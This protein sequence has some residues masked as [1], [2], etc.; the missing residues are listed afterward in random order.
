[1]RERVLVAIVVAVAGLLLA[2]PTAQAQCVRYVSTSYGHF[3]QFG[4]VADGVTNTIDGVPVDMT[5]GPAQI[6]GAG[7]PVD[8]GWSTHGVEGFRAYITEG[9]VPTEHAFTQIT[10]WV[11]TVDMKKTGIKGDRRAIPPLQVY[12]LYFDYRGE[13]VLSDGAGAFKNATGHVVTRGPFFLDLMNMPD[14]TP[15][16]AAVFGAGSGEYEFET[17]GM[18]CGADLKA[19]GLR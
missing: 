4:W 2:G 8:R 18:I 7:A 5:A 17:T 13:G 16:P 19:L 10:R 6:E 3:G 11:G 9:G 15:V 14:G 1:M 12:R